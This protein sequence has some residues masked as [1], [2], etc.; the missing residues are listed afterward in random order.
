M[1]KFIDIGEP[2]NVVPLQENSKRTKFNE[3]ILK[4][5]ICI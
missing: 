4:Y 1:N 2:I 3:V 5:L